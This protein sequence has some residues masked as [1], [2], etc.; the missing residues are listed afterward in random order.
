[1]LHEDWPSLCPTDAA[2]R[3]D[4]LYAYADALKAAEAARQCVKRADAGDFEDHCGVIADALS[5]VEGA[6]ADAE[7][8]LGVSERSDRDEHGTWNHAQSGVSR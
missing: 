8:A 5:E 6:I 3:L 4:A 7:E 1:M 2:D